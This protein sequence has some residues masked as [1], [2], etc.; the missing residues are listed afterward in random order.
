MRLIGHRYAGPVITGVADHARDRLA[1]LIY[2]D[3]HAPE[4]GESFL[5]LQDAS[6][7]ADSEEATR[8]GDEG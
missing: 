6:K 5:Q 1:S 4:D 3:A 2:L 7:R 8:T